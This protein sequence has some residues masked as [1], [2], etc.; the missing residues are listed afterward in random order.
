MG[1]TFLKGTTFKKLYSSKIKWLEPAPLLY[2]LKR[3]SNKYSK[4]IFQTSHLLFED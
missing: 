2:S 1:I 4:L 3:Y